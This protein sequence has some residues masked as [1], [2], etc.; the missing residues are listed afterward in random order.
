MRVKGFNLH[1][2]QREHAVEFILAGLDR[3]GVHEC[4][5]ELKKHRNNRDLQ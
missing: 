2:S 5:I 4:I 3:C 1:A